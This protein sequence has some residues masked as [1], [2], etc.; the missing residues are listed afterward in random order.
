MT[1]YWIFIAVAGMASAQWVHYPDPGTP[2]TKDGE[3]NLNAPAP[4]L[5]DGRPDLSGVWQPDG[6]PPEDLIRASYGSRTPPA[7]G[8]DP[9]N[10]YFLNVLADFQPGP[11]PLTPTART[12][13]SKTTFVSRGYDCLPLGMPVAA[14]DPGPVKFV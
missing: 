12:A 4:R 8:S 1:P 6:S 7:L 3:A 13:F 10:K 2:R 9:P 14:T 11:E 5:K